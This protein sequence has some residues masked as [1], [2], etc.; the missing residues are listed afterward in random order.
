MFRSSS[1]FLSWGCISLHLVP[2][3]IIQDNVPIKILNLLTSAEIF[4]PA[5]PP[6]IILHLQVPGIGMQISFRSI[7]SILPESAPRPPK[8]HINSKCKIHPPPYS[9]TPTFLKPLCVNSAQ[10]SHVN[11]VGLQS[12]KFHHLYLIIHPLMGNALGMIYPETKFLTICV[13]VK[14]EKVCFQNAVI[15]QAW[16][17]HSII[18]LFQ[19]GENSRKESVTSSEHF[20]KSSRVHSIRMQG[21]GII[22]CSLSSHCGPKA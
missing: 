20:Q 14:V 1:A 22:L 17:R 16:D 7:F 5:P 6:Q 9:G 19:M 3:W 8:I 18:F 11:I 21:L 4:L 12:P 13:P 2:T 10:K 15:A